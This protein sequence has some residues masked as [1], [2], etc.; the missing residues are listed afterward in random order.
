MHEKFYHKR[1]DHPIFPELKFRILLPVEFFEFYFRIGWYVLV[2]SRYW[3]NPK[4]AGVLFSFMVTAKEKRT[5]RESRQECTP[6]IPGRAWI[7]TTE[8]RLVIFL[9][10]S[11]FLTSL[12]GQYCNRSDRVLRHFNR[13]GFD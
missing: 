10:D 3:R 11:G 12:P 4:L 6:E 9:R 8:R 1:C 2:P 5:K 7:I 13:M